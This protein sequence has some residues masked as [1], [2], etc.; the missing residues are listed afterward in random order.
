MQ[1]LPDGGDVD[2]ELFADIH[3]PD[4]VGVHLQDSF[5]QRFSF[6]SFVADFDAGLLQRSA[7]GAPVTAELCGQF[8]GARSGAVLFRDLPD[9]VIGQAFLLLRISIDFGIGIIGDVGHIQVDLGGLAEIEGL[10]MLCSVFEYPGGRVVLV[11]L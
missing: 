2:A 7:D 4:V 5:C 11:S 1:D 6:G 8:I 9:L 10:V 3:W